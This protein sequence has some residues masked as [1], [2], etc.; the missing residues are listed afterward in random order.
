MTKT[1]PRRIGGWALGGVFCM[2]MGLTGQAAAY[3]SAP[4]TDGGVVQG[5]VTFKG[6]PPPPKVFDLSRFPDK[7]FCGGI[8]DAQGDRLLR[9]VIAGQDGGL[10]DVVVVIEGVPRGKPFTFESAKMEANICQFFPFVSVVS[11]KR[12]I[13]VANRDPVSHDIQ[14][15]A[16]DQHG[17]DIV[18][19]RAALDKRGTT[20][21]VNLTKGRKVFTMQC[22][23]HPYMQSWGYAIENPYHAVTN[24]DGGFTIGDLPAGTYRVKAWHPILGSQEQTVTVSASGTAPLS[25]TFEYR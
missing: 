19:H 10:K 14:G 3:D 18:L 2:G 5:T 23:R 16:Y 4:V 21:V 25:F 6:T 17:V 1:A 7:R 15:Y 9:E 8:S 12:Q 11:D 24:L 13:T 20:D 22:G